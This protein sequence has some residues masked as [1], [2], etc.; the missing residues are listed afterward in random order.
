MQ[1]LV[2]CACTALQLN[3]YEPLRTSAPPV[4]VLGGAKRFRVPRRLGLG[5]AFPRHPLPHAPAGEA[6][7]RGR[8][9]N[10]AA[11]DA[12]NH[13]VLVHRVLLPLRMHRKIAH[14]TIATM[15]MSSERRPGSA[16]ALFPNLL[17]CA[18]I[19][20]QPP[21]TPGAP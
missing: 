17:F 15:I 14:A 2:G 7:R 9:G 21:L 12:A 8:V 3:K 11:S 6:S 20:G 4:L 16:S 5:R 18:G 1:L 10:Y 19:R 13:N